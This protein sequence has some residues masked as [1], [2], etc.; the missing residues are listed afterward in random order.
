MLNKAYKLRYLP[1]F[2]DDLYGAVTYIRTK[3]KNPDAADRLIDKVEEAILERTSCAE[4]FEP[5]PSTRKRELPYYPIY[6]NNYI[7]FYVVIDHEIMEVRRFLYQ[8]QNK[9]KII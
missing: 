4:S 1:V 7:I 9:D 3:L 8:R 6:V 5:Y 2:Y